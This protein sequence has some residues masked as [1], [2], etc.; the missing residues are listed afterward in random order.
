[1]EDKTKPSVVTMINFAV[2]FLFVTLGDDV[3]DKAEGVSLFSTRLYFRQKMNGPNQGNQ[4]KRPALIFMLKGDPTWV[5][6]QY[7]Q[8]YR[9][10]RLQLTSQYAPNI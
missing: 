10:L 5:T 7:F 6:Q 3:K 9:Q 4:K 2:L 1:M 8:A